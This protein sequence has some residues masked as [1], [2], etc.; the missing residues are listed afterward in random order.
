MV[1]VY[2]EEIDYQDYCEEHTHFTVEMA[3]LSW[4]EDPLLVIDTDIFVFN[5]MLGQLTISSTDRDKIGLYH[6]LIKERSDIASTVNTFTTQLSVTV[7]DF[8]V[9]AS[10]M[11]D[12]A[13]AVFEFEY[14]AGDDSLVID[15]ANIENSFTVDE[16]YSS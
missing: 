7:V 13:E 2:S 6:L 4:A 12:P 1:I 8:C 14:M 11:V 3:D 16:G 15:L 9:N 10:L 5:E